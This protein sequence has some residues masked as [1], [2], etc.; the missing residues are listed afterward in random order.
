MSI[1]TSK[2][3]SKIILLSRYDSLDVIMVVIQN[4]TKVSNLYV[5]VDLIMD[6]TMDTFKLYY[7]FLH[8][9]K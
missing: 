7:N 9:C 4:I 1:T 2:L 8:D 3:T 6:V 5:I